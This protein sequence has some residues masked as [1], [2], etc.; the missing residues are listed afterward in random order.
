MLSLWRQNIDLFREITT[1]FR[2]RRE[3][4]PLDSIEEV[5]GFARSRAA[6][7]TQKK[8]YGYVKTRMGTSYPKMF[9][10]EPFAQSMNIA[11]MHIFAAGLADMTMF[12]TAN[13]TPGDA[14]SDPDREEIAR[15]CYAKGLDE[16]DDGAVMTEHREAWTAALEKRF[17]GAVWRLL[18]PSEAHFR[19]SPQALVTWAPISDRLKKFDAEIVENSLR[20]AWVDPRREFFRRLD[21]DAVATSWRNR[22]AE[23]A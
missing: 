17:G 5:A 20:F 16:N 12:C 11:K 4:W 3:A 10:D 1:R 13:A 15:A 9:E 6:Y 18:G 23:G 14:F 8:L 2:V 22:Q 7:V 21:V 19:E